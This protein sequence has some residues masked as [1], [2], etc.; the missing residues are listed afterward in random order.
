MLFA[1]DLRLV[2]KKTS[3]KIAYQHFETAYQVIC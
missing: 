3:G 2:L 1:R